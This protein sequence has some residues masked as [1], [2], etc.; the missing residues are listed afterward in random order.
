[1]AVAAAQVSVGTSAT[2]LNAVDA[3]PQSVLVRSP[4]AATTSVYVGP[5]TVTTG[6]G[7][8][9]PAGGSLSMDLAAGEQ[10]YG[11]VASGTQTVHVLRAAVG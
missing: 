6:N 3:D 8:E 2:V 4:S 7:F 9:L 5:S 10:L 1:M 11:I